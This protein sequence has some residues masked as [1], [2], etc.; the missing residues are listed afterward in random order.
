LNK[1]LT[2]M[3]H[4]R[5]TFV[6]LYKRVKDIFFFFE[7]GR[8]IFGLNPVYNRSEELRGY[9]TGCADPSPL[10]IQK[11]ASTRAYCAMPIH[12]LLNYRDLSRQ[13]GVFFVARFLVRSVAHI[14]IAHGRLYH[15]PS[16]TD[17]GRPEQHLSFA[18]GPGCQFGWTPRLA[19]NDLH[20]INLCVASSLDTFHMQSPSKL[21]VKN[22]SQIFKFSDISKCNLTEPHQNLG[23]FMFPEKNHHFWLVYR[24]RKTQ[25]SKPS[26]Q[27]L[28][29]STCLPEIYTTKLSA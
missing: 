21:S 17:K 12:P 4:K 16:Q 9:L 2:K 10:S 24:Q 1:K 25:I 11:W 29:T 8:C 28:T 6:N 26:H 15:T 14:R 5:L 13:P 27:S 23:I 3:L 22:Y 19:R 20:K 7:K 18:N